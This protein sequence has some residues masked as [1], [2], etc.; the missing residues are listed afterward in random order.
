MA[1]IKGGS[2]VVFALLTTFSLFNPF[3]KISTLNFF[4]ISLTAG[5]LYV[6]GEKVVNTVGKEI[7]SVDLSA[8][9]LG[10]KFIFL[11]LALPVV[12]IFI[13]NLL[14]IPIATT[15]IVV[16]TMIGIGL[17]LKEINLFKVTEIVIWWIAT[18]LILWFSNYLIGKHLYLK[19]WEILKTINYQF[20]C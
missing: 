8:H 19:I 14:K 6:G 15:H 20:H 7:V 10:I 5:I 17:A 4:G 3:L 9:K 11:I 12:C 16:C 1:S 2:P 13:A 18:P